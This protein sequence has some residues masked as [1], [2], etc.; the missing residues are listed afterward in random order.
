MFTDIYIYIYMYVHINM[1][2][3]MHYAHPFSS[4]T[5]SS[6]VE[7]S[8]A[9]WRPASN[10]ASIFTSATSFTTY[11]HTYKKKKAW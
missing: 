8:S 9:I 10:F 11:I 7:S 5:V 4:S 6:N 1:Y 2:V 3:Y